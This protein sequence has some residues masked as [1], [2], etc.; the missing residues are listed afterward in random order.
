MGKTVEALSEGQFTKNMLVYTVCVGVGA[1]MVAGS[2]K[3]LFGVNVIFLILGKYSVA[4]LLTGE[5]LF[6]HV[7]S[8][9]HA[10]SLLKG[11]S[12]FITNEFRTFISV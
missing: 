4:C 12:L 7:S 3:I 9:S 2:C 8:S 11:E 5:A 1:G 6:M 10:C